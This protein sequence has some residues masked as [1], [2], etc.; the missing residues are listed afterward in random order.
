MKMKNPAFYSSYKSPLGNV[1]SLVAAAY[2]NTTK[3][4]RNVRCLD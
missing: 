4:N 3:A 1:S 2:A